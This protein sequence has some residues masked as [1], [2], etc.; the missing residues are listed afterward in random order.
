MDDI[1]GIRLKDIYSIV[2]KRLAQILEDEGI[3]TVG[4]L[5]SLDMEEFNKYR[6]ADETLKG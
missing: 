6:E 1:S 5:D 3:H 2:P 4:E